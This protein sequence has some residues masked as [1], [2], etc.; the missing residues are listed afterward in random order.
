MEPPQAPELYPFPDVSTLKLRASLKE[1]QERLLSERFALS[2][3]TDHHEGPSSDLALVETRLKELKKLLSPKTW[4]LE[5]AV[6]FA[7]YVENWVEPYGYHVGVVGSVLT[8]GYSVNDLDML[9]Y[10]A[11]SKHQEQRDYIRK[12]V[13]H[14]AGMRLTCERAFV[15]EQWRKA[16]SDDEKHVEVFHCTE[17]VQGC[18]GRRVDVFFLS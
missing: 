15:T 1:E 12:S 4:W 11:S 16:G 6:W 13:L 8:Q 14:K 5:E 2:D 3:P 18:R 7:R 9:L 17:G 10:P